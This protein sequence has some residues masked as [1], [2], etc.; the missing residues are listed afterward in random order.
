MAGL[1]SSAQHSPGRVQ[2]ALLAGFPA[3]PQGTLLL[4]ATARAP[5]LLQGF[6]LP[7]AAAI[8]VSD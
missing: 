4:G 2:A 3:W 6:G 8:H 7:T 1:D 5:G